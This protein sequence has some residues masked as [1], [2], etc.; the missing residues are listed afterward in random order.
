M[1]TPVDT[2]ID[3]LLAKQEIRDAL[4]RYCRGIDRL[5][6]EMVR[7]AYHPGAYDDHGTYKGPVEGFIEHV[8]Q[9]LRRF[10][11]TEHFIGNNL[12]EVRGDRAVS[13]TYVVAY[14]RFAAEGDQPEKDFF[15]GGRYVDLF[16]RKN[17]RW[18]ISHRTVVHSWSRTDP[19]GEG[20]AAQGAFFQG[21]RGDRSDRVYELLKE[22]DA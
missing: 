2:A 1:A 3:I 22:L 18:L 13:E 21:D 17:G 15:F 11:A 8:G 12:I 4:V 20:W 19:V 16:E 7:S 5:D 6:M 10:K 14:H 9:G